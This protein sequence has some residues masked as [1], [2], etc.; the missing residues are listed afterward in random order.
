MTTIAAI[1]GDNYVVVG[2]D[3]R[4]SS[5]DTGG[6]AY[7]SS[8]LGNGQSKIALSKKYLLGAA[9]DVRAINILHHVFQ[10]PAV[11]ANLR[12]KKL[13][14]FITSKFVPALRSCFEQQ[15]YAM[16]E[17]KQAKEKGAEQGSS[18]VVV[19]NATIYII[20]NDYSWTSEAGGLYSVGTGAAYALGSLHALTASKG[21]SAAQAKRVVLKSL[22]IAAKCDPY[23]G[24]PFHAYTQEI[25]AE[26]K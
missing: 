4:I 16:P 20:E 17:E 3:T 15:G 25:K 13:D 14:Q 5:F 9:G 10:P 7:Q 18:V 1:Q 23:T 19:V 24:G 21:L 2:A 22:Q 12:G 26:E 8:T 6:F 11:P